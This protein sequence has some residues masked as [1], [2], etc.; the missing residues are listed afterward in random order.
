MIAESLLVFR[1]LTGHQGP[2][3]NA[4]PSLMQSG[5]GGQPG[6]GRISAPSRRRALTFGS[7]TCMERQASTP[8]L[9]GTARA[10]AGIR[11]DAA[12][13]QFGQLVGAVDTLHSM[14]VPVPAA[15]RDL[16]QPPPPL[17]VDSCSQPPPPASRAAGRL[18]A[19]RRPAAADD[20]D[21]ADDDHGSISQA[22]TMT[23]AA[24]RRLSTA[25]GEKS[26]LFNAQLLEQM[27]PVLTL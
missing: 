10:A 4:V 18:R 17:Q 16:L 7:P 13:S 3:A 2:E 9:R 22:G 11:S 26:L 8:V 12:S 1:F 27:Q 14:T 24:G 6:S 15:S 25:S 19:R 20:H 21:G 23:P 5:D